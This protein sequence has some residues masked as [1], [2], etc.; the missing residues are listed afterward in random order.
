MN[1][2]SFFTSFSQLHFKHNKECFVLL[3]HYKGM[4]LH[5]KRKR[6]SYTWIFDFF[7]GGEKDVLIEGSS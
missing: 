7:R 6:R 1:V 3:D 5:L 4:V 2:K